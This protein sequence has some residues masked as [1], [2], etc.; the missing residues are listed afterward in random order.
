M[1]LV[2]SYIEETGLQLPEDMR[3]DVQAELRELIAEQVADRATSQEREP[4]L[5]DE[6]AVLQGLGHPVKMARSY[7]PQRFLIGP[8]SYP[9]YIHVLKVAIF[10]VISLQL[11][12][13]LL[14]KDDLGLVSVLADATG[15]ALMVFAVVTGIFAA[16]EASGESLAWQANW[17]PDSLRSGPRAAV[18]TGDLATSLIAEGIGL[19]WW[20][21]LLRF[22]F[23]TDGIGLSASLSAAWEPLRWPLNLL[24]GVSFALHV[25]L[26]IRGQWRQWTLLLELLLG[27]ATLAMIGYLLS[28]DVLATIE[29]SELGDRRVMIDWSVRGLLASIAVF[30]AWDLFRYA[31]LWRRLRARSGA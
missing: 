21:D 27:G 15:S 22:P 20:N 26:V 28:C 29:P 25:Y 9:D 1:K 30:V 23:L 17:T 2:D 8:G 6:R 4:S 3:A 19:L 24:L 12:A 31:G 10:V 18:Q 11:L 14:L 13:R 7:L 5:E 16:L